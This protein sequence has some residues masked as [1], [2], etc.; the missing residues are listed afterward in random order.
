MVNNLS[1]MDQPSVPL[2]GRPPAEQ[3]PPCTPSRSWMSGVFDVV[4][5]ISFFGV[6][7][8]L[9]VQSNHEK[10]HLQ[11]INNLNDFISVTQK[12]NQLVVEDLQTKHTSAMNRRMCIHGY[13]GENCETACGKHST[14][15]HSFLSYSIEDTCGTVTCYEG[16]ELTD[17]GLCMIT[18][19]HLYAMAKQYIEASKH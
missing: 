5:W 2:A 12:S 4:I 6:M 7:I 14:P 17:A 13:T 1:E 18:N 19:E 8:W 3:F 10:I 16:Y 15:R 11:T 9:V